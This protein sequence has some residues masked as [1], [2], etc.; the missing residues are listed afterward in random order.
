[1]LTFPIFSPSLT[2]SRFDIVSPFICSSLA[3]GQNRQI[4][5]TQLFS[6]MRFKIFWRDFNARHQRKDQRRKKCHF[7]DS[8]VVLDIFANCNISNKLQSVVGYSGRKEKR[9]KQLSTSADSQ[10]LV[11]FISTYTHTNRHIVS[12]EKAYFS[13]ILMKWLSRGHRNSILNHFRLFAR[14]LLFQLPNWV[15]RFVS[16]S[17]SWLREAPRECRIGRERGR[18]REREYTEGARQ[19][20]RNRAKGLAKQKHLQP[21]VQTESRQNIKGIYSIH[22][23]IHLLDKDPPK[24][25]KSNKT[26]VL[27]SLWG[28]FF[29]LL[30]K[31][32]NLII[33]PFNYNLSTLRPFKVNQVITSS[34]FFSLFAFRSC[35]SNS[36]CLA[37]WWKMFAPIS[38]LV[39]RSTVKLLRRGMLWA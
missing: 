18:E 5:L 28:N 17:Q 23:W 8:L 20:E 22:Y 9:G 7:A 36:C 32:Y 34:A 3:T 16:H 29:S 21:N 19:I 2:T 4:L 37:N 39:Q 12:T 24:N 25:E 35:P 31:E 6:E 38:E 33:I 13:L 1:M 10:T 15:N 30:Q 27:Y 14:H 11:K 26:I